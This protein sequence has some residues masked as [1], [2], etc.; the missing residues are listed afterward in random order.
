MKKYPHSI[1]FQVALLSTHSSTKK[2]KSY[3]AG[4]PY[5]YT[6]SPRGGTATARGGQEGC[7]EEKWQRRKGQEYAKL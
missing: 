6:L 3:H 4:S 2:N 7:R 1:L 5:V